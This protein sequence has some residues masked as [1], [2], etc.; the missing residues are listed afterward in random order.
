[1]KRTALA[2]AVGLL[3]SA[4]ANAAPPPLPTGKVYLKYN[5]LEQIGPGNSITSPS[6]AA[7]QNWGLGDWNTI[8]Q[9]V[10]GTEHVTFSKGATTWTD[11]SGGE[12]TA[13]FWG[14]TS[15]A[16][17]PLASTRAVGGFLDLYW[18]PVDEAVSGAGT[19][20]NLPAANR[21]VPSVPPVPYPESP[22]PGAGIDNTFP[23]ITDGQF[24]VRLQFMPGCDGTV[25]ANTALYTVCSTASIASPSVE[26]QATVY[27][28]V[29]D[30]NGDGS[31]N[32][33][34]G[35]WAYQLNSDWF[36]TNPGGGALAKRDVY[37]SNHFTG[38]TG[39]G[40]GW[41]DL[42][43]I[44]AANSDDPMRAFA[45]PEPATIALFSLG[46]LGLGV[47]RRNKAK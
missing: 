27:A 19:L 37:F 14:I 44:F 40:N 30:A 18:D 42:P 13:I 45:V 23:L 46:L 3:S 1:M 22:G 36:W 35:L 43:L 31:I 2:L 34:D 11:L 25:G 15:I 26:G 16:G 9:G 21:G 47:S 32:S 8:A 38:D 5:N 28:D 39:A 12:I 6:G 33:A 7:E 17:D 24:L 10:G 20:L 29:V 41:N 4:A